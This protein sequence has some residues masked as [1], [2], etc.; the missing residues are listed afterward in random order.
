MMSYF[1]NLLLRMNSI[2][3]FLLDLNNNFIQKNKI[4]YHKNEKFVKFP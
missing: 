1:I 3:S 4:F 2:L